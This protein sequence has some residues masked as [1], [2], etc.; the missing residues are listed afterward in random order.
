MPEAHELVRRAAVEA[1]HRGVDLLEVVEGDP[2][3]A[4]HLARLGPQQREA[5]RNPERLVEPA[6]RQALETA[7]FWEGVLGAPASP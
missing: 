3:L 7:E 6:R 2:A 1:R 5:L 4:P